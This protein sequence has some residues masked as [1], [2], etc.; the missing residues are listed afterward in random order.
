[1]SRNKKWKYKYIACILLYLR[2]ANIFALW[3]VFLARDI[4]FIVE[5]FH[6]VL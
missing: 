6:Y 4:L 2:G 3:Y 5:S 1:M